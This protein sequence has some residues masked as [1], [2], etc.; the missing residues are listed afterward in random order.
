M[1]SFLIA[2]Q[3][4]TSGLLSFTLYYLLQNQTAYDAARREVDE[5]LGTDVIAV[6]YL[7]KLPFLKAVLRESLRLTPP[8]PSII[9]TPHK[10]TFLGEEKYHV[11][12]GTPIIAL[13]SMVHRDKTVYGD[14]AEDFRPARMLEEEFNKRNKKFRSCW[15]PFGNGRRS[16]IGETFAMQNALLVLALLLQR[17]DFSMEDT[18]YKLRIKQT[19]TIK[20][21]GF[22]VRAKLREKS[23][24]ERK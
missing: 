8:V 17:F 4:T 20:P 2:G 13:P 16:C 11:K 9:V 7:A 6:D 15:K 12:C 5:V 1:I 10:D 3:D 14:D 18:N 22:G 23:N 21:D 24:A 19:L